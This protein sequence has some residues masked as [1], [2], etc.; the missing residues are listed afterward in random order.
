QNRTPENN[1]FI[2]AFTKKFSAT[3]DQFAAQAYDAMYI[4]ADALKKTKLSGNLTADR[5]A[6]RDALPAVKITGATG[7]FAFRR[8]MDKSGKPAGYDAEQV[9]IVS[10][11][12]DGKFSIEK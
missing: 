11:T 6:L 4:V 7:S 12:K 8:A 3:P 2:I 5:T 1:S 10:V 9:P